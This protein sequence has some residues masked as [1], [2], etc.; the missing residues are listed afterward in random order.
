M[1]IDELIALLGYRIEGQDK[2]KQFVGGIDA[3]EGKLRKASAAMN[4]MQVAVGSFIGSLA[5]TAFMRLADS[6]GSIP[7]DVIKVSAQFEGFQTS[8]ETI[9]GSS[10]KAKASMDWI[11]QF[12]AKTPYELAGITDA[13]IKLKARGFDPMDGTLAT[14]GDTASAMN[15]PLD[16]AVEAFT[17][18]ATMQFERLKEF[19]IISSQKGDQ[20]TFSWQENGKAM[21]KTVKKTSK[22]VTDFLRNVFGTRFNG[23]MVRQSKTWN[24]MLS[25]LSDSWNLFMKRIG[26]KGIFERVKGLLGGLLDYIG[27]LDADGTLDRWAQSI[28]DGMG[29]AVNELINLG[30]KLKG[31]W[32]FISQWATLNP[33]WIKPLVTG[34]G[35]LAALKFPRLAAL[36][37]IDDILSALQGKASVIGDFAKYLNELTDIDTDTLTKVLAAIAAFGV[38]ALLWG[39]SFG[40]VARGIAALAAALI[41]MGGSKVAA[42]ATALAGLAGSSI[43]TGLLSIA[44]AAGA[45]AGAI[46]LFYDAWSQDTKLN[47][48]IK[49]KVAPGLFNWFSDNILGTNSAEDQYWRSGQGEKD[50]A[51]RKARENKVNAKQTKKTSSSTNWATPGYGP[52]D[53]RMEEQRKETQ[54]MLNNFNRNS[55]NAIG[56]DQAPQ[57]IIND[58][59]NKSINVNPVVNIDVQRIEQAADAAASATRTAVSNAASK[60]AVQPKARMNPGQF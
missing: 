37:V 33:D 7:G 38:G 41:T 6:I 39:G 57:Q 28:S 3:V 53:W 55:A 60:S 50:A 32:D 44:A 19:G 20:V 36:L 27:K 35:L 49:E 43:A 42:G 34:L 56:G 45:A 52:D 17:D 14:L 4:T 31:H 48:A 59:S 29:T 51:A 47:D 8:L 40:I 54:R 25:N 26:D 21:S 2:L 15:K 16:Q 22:D 5:T 58:S 46:K 10:E 12:A 9:E 13:F 30:A 1:I 23:A 11:A 24:G 18:A